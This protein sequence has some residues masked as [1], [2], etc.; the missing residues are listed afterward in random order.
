MSRKRRL[1]RH[2]NFVK[3]FKRVSVTDNQFERLTVWEKQS[4]TI[5]E[6]KAALFF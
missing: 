1:E 6:K 4:L 5:E 2:K 3:D